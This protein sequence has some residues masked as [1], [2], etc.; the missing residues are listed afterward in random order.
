[1]LISALY[2]EIKS[3]NLRKGLESVWKRSGRDSLAVQGV[4]QARDVE[5]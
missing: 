4:I 5:P 3:L 1:M 2:A